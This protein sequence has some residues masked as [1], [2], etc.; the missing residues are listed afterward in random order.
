VA[1][2]IP[3]TG[4]QKCFLYF[5]FMHGGVCTVARIYVL[6]IVARIYVFMHGGTF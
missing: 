5:Y 2:R 4:N 1:R 3:L 6:C